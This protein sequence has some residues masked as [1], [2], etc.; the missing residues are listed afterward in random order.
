[1]PQ[2]GN[3]SRGFLQWVRN[4]IIQDVPEDVALCEFDCRKGNCTNEE[5]ESCGRRLDRAEGELL[6]SSKDHP[7]A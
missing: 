7:A 1:M 4:Q 3:L 6:P 2:L 5:W